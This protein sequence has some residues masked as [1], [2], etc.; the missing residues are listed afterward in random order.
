M[1][2]TNAKNGIASDI[3]NKP[4][5]SS[6]IINH[7]NISNMLKIFALV[8]LVLFIYKKSTQSQYEDDATLQYCISGA[9]GFGSAP[10]P[11]LVAGPR[12]RYF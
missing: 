5:L 12:G 1:S 2:I 4:L 11:A 6:A 10:S 7:L 8:L 3:S 9:K